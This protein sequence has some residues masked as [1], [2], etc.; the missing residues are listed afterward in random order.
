VENQQKKL[1]PMLYNVIAC[2]YIDTIH[3]EKIDHKLHMEIIEN[4]AKF[5]QSK[6][7]IKL[8]SGYMKNYVSQ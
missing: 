7:M 4:I 2:I 6:K 3:F 5:L 1:Q 8:Q